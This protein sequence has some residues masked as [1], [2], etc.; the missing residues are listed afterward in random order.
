MKLASKVPWPRNVHQRWFGAG[1]G[2]LVT[3]AAGW[4]CYFTYLGQ[5]F[6]EVS[7]DYSFFFSKDQPV[8]E[9]IIVYMDD[10]SHR[11][12]RQDPN[13]LW[14]RSL[15]AKL[16]D[17][18]TQD[19]A[20]A[21]VLDIVF[22]STNDMAAA[23]S[24]EDAGFRSR[25]ENFQRGTEDLAAAMRRHGNVVLAGLFTPQA[26]NP[27]SGAVS[28]AGGSTEMPAAELLTS[29]RG[30]GLSN[31]D[32]FVR[33][34][35]SGTP[36]QPSLAWAA[37]EAAGAEITRS[38]QNRM[39]ERWLKYYG[40]PGSLPHVR[41]SDVMK[42]DGVSP[43]LFQGKVVFVGA[44][45]TAGVVHAQLDQFRTPHSRWLSEMMPGVEVQATACLNLQRGD[46]FTRW[47]TL[48]EVIVIGIAGIALGAGLVLLSPVAAALTAI[49]VALALTLTGLMLLPLTETWFTWAAMAGVQVPTA[50][51][52]SLVYNSVRLHVEKRMLKESLVL[53]LSPH[54]VDQILKDPKLLKPGAEMQEVSIMF[55]DIANF[56][57][58]TARMNPED[59]FQMLN[60]YF[61]RAL[62]CIHETDGTVV[63]LIGDSVFA[64][65]NAPFVQPDQ[66]E[67]ACRAALLLQQNII[68][69]EETH[70]SL[71]LRTR[72]GLHTGTACVGNVG[73]TK[74]F[75]Y[76]AIGDSINV[77]SR[78]EGLNKFLGTEILATRDIQKVVERS[79]TSRKVGYFR[80]KGSD[81]Y[82]EVHEILGGT[83]KAESLRVFC[84]AFE[85]ALFHF[86]RKNWEAAETEF[87]RVLEIKPV[88]GP[89]LFYLARIAEFRAS[90]PPEDWAGEIELKEK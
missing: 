45:A 76:T 55:T 5:Y 6:R 81:R 7:Y 77:A 59:L 69:F 11:E 46:W 36:G 50:L 73:S 16:V 21:V 35:P 31:L 25:L 51:V 29:A 27:V 43:N 68:E 53:H 67:R 9:L 84:A 57:K 88:D 2:T 39:Q 79:F 28:L 72:I 13:G 8:N 75:D 18:L 30:W 63:K 89:S 85:S 26:D 62:S 65:W 54:R 49:G 52:F 87:K 74:R 14:D 48:V 58:I 83:E 78:L 17:R 34:L 37:A 82:V 80:F 42:P 41:Y 33:Q 61:E 23:G 47:P 12:L 56:T 70:H 71:P 44:K 38:P 60:N 10:V 22:S 4:I 40:P 1:I 90:P 15:H 32:H 20:K 66:Q 86:Q 24:L 64:I 3:L 19:R